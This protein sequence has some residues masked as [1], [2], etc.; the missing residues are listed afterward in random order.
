M[1]KY[2]FKTEKEY[3]KYI[4]EYFLPNEIHIYVNLNYKFFSRPF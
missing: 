3:L 4:D 1:L 2:N